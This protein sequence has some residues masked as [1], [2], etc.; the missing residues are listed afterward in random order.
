[1]MIIVFPVPQLKYPSTREKGSA[2]YDTVSDDVQ[3]FPYRTAQVRN[4]WLR[5]KL[6]R[7]LEDLHH[8]LAVATGNQRGNHEVYRFTHDGNTIYVW[9]CDFEVTFGWSVLEERY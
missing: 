7:E 1:M 8:R 3:L 9:F 2:M 5:L 4:R 6:N